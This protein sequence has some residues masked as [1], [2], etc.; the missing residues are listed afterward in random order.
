MRGRLNALGTA[1]ELWQCEARAALGEGATA[2]RYGGAGRK[3]GGSSGR[4]SPQAVEA[5]LARADMLRVV[6]VRGCGC[7]ESF[8]DVGGVGRSTH[9]NKL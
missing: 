1:A 4:S 9:K 8:N 5:L 6:Q 3:M 2:A 7:G